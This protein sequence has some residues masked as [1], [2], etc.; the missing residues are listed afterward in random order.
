MLNDND[1]PP[2]TYARMT[3]TVMRGFNAEAFANI[4][5]NSGY[6]VSDLARLSGVGLATIHAWEG[7]RGTPQIDRLVRA[8]TVLNA[9]IDHVVT[10]DRHDRYPS[11]WR[12]IRGLTQPQLAAAARIATTTLRRIERGDLP[13]TDTNAETLARLLDITPTEYRAAY[14]RARTRPPGTPV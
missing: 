7:H 10:I 13:L 1:H 4:R 8:M 12:V 11:D 5:R 14:E 9:P 2:R 6:T 3:K